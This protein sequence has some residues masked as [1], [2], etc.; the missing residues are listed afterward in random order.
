MPRSV[1]PEVKLVKWMVT[2]ACKEYFDRCHNGAWLEDYYRSTLDVVWGYLR[3]TKTLNGSCSDFQCDI[4]LE[5]KRA[6][7]GDY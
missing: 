6:L 7:M 1:I 3:G 4:A 5:I 2:G